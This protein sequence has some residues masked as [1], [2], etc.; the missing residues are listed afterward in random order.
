MKELSISVDRIFFP[1]VTD[2]AVSSCKAW[3]LLSV[4]LL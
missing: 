4:C 3:S 1:K 2:N